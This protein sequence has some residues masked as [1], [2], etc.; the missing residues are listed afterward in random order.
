[1]A[2]VT[3]LERRTCESCKYERTVKVTYMGHPEP[4]DPFWDHFCKACVLLSRAA[5]QRRLA[6]KNEDQANELLA[7]RRAGLETE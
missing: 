2:I 3:K 4:K 1:M 7:L 5:S 6:Q